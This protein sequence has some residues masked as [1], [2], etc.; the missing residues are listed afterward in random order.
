MGWQPWLTARLTADV[1]V[2]YAR[3]PENVRRWA[4]AAAGR[5]KDLE[6]IAELEALLAEKERS[7]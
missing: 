6:A 7:S 3:H 5:P 2:V 4:A 1:H